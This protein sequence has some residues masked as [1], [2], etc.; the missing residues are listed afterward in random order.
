MPPEILLR[1]QTAPLTPT[2]R[3]KNRY[4]EAIVHHLEAQNQRG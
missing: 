2:S 3:L 4:K 1:I